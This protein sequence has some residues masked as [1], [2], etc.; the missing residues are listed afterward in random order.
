M[1]TNRV[2]HRNAA[3]IVLPVDALTVWAAV[4][5]DPPELMI[6]LRGFRD[7]RIAAESRR[8]RSR[9]QALEAELQRRLLLAL[10]H[11][12]LSGEDT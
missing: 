12:R 7:A 9:L 2:G 4:D 6:N 11:E 8:L 1:I 3:I 5:Y 10:L